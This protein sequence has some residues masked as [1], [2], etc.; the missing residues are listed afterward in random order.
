MA[1][2][3][4]EAMDETCAFDAG[5]GS[6]TALTIKKCEGCRFRKSEEQLIRGRERA[7]ARI[8]TFTKEYRAH[9]KARYYSQ[10]EQAY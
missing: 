5:D 2:G 6:C 4:S 7:A 3:L 1:K 8:K 9:I 10:K